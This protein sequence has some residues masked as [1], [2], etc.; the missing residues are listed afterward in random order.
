MKNLIII[1]ILFFSLISDSLSQIPDNENFIITHGPYIQNLSSSGVTIIWTTNRPAVPTIILTGIDGKVRFISNSHDGLVDA[2]GMLHKVRIEG[3]EPGILYKYTVNSVQILKYQAYVVYYGD[4]I[5]GKKESFSTP[6]LNSEKV[7][8]SVM[9]DVHEN[10][11]KMASYLKY[12]NTAGADFFIFNGDMVDFLQNTDQLFTSFIDTAVSYFASRKSFYYVRG[13]HETRGYVARD[14]K[15]YFDTKENRFYYSFDN[16]P[17]HFV[18]LDCGEGKP[19][20][21][22][23]YFGLVDFEKYKLEELEWLKNEVK[24][25]AF[26]KAK[27]RIV[28]IHM[29]VVKEDNQA[30]GLKFLADNFGPVLQGTG[31]DLMLSA[32]IHRN[33]FYESGKSGFGYPVLV[34]SNET[35]IEVKADMNSIKAEVKD[36][37]GRILNSYTVK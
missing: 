27:Y 21:D 24:S 15:N 30:Y 9:N 16:G 36:V 18:V 8:F 35:F 10:S 23:S 7:T 34:N 3:L 29:P 20:N 4:T 37:S 19:D 22:R 25:D 13:N 26:R 28:L 1:S 33:A 17:V 31:V 12:G 5:R 14:L 2:G 11:G 6:A 32:H